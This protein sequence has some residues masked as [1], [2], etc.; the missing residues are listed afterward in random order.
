[1]PAPPQHDDAHRPT[2]DRALSPLLRNQMSGHLEGFERRAMPLEGRRAAAVT[3]L[4]VDG[5]AGEACFV[6]TRRAPKLRSHGGQWALPGGRLDPGEDAV[7]AALRESREEVGA[8]CDEP[9]VL[10]LLDDYPTRSGFVMTPVVIWGGS[11]AAMTPEPSEV[12]TIYRVPLGEL[13][14][15]EVPHVW[16]IPESPRPC[17]A[18]PLVGTRINA[19]TAAT[20]FQFREVC[21]HGRAT[22]VDHY[23]QPVF[24]WK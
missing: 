18:I 13:E 12:E 4:L 3:L 14:R 20:I 10:G 23:E 9:H 8:V 11:G 16:N 7:T 22:R 17:I 24:A 21:I 19:P 5:T 6:L 1:M 2:A 15:P